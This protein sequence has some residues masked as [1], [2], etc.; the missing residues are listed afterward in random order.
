MRL[1]LKQTGP[2]SSARDITACIASDLTI[3]NVKFPGK[4]A[5][6]AKGRAWAG[7]RATGEEEL[8]VGFSRRRGG[9]K[10]KSCAGK[11]GN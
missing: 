10:K 5:R 1:H 4:V 7:L 6:A 11:D 2:R 8:V 3:S 9:K